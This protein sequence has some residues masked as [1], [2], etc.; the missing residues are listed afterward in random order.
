MGTRVR[1][2]APDD[3]V[4]GLVWQ[5]HDSERI[6]VLQDLPAG[7]TPRLLT[8]SAAQVSVPPASLARADAAQ[9]AVA[10]SSGP[11]ALS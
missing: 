6:D 10:A 2:R 7:C 5:V 8:V 1:L 3:D 9:V 11:S 4:G